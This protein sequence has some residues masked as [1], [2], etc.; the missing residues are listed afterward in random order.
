MPF[1]KM[2]I[3]PVVVYGAS[4]SERT[5]PFA[6]NDYG[7]SKQKAEQYSLTAYAPVTV[8]L[9]ICFLKAQYMSMLLQHRYIRALLY[10]SPCKRR[11]SHEVTVHDQVSGCTDRYRMVMLVS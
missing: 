10:M 1:H 8:C 6:N 4:P 3:Y 11:L 2:I 5:S 9:F 7:I